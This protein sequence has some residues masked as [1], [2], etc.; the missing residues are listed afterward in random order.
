MK[1]TAKLA[2]KKDAKPQF[3]PNKL[4]GKWQTEVK[5]D[6]LTAILELTLNKDGSSN[7]N[8]NAEMEGEIQDGMYMKLPFVVNANNGKWGINASILSLNYSEAISNCSISKI[9]IKGLEGEEKET[10]INE[11]Q[12]LFEQNKSELINNVDFSKLLK[13]S[14]LI[15]QEV[16][17]KELKVTDGTTIITFKKIK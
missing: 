9:E 13:S 16:R 15:I 2:T 7:I 14:E 6:N 17:D 11:L 4:H 5:Q 8:V 10:K 12:T 1:K 3:K